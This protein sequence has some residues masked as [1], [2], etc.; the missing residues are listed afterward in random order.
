M[1]AHHLL[2]RLTPPLVAEFALCL[3]THFKYMDFETVRYITLHAF[4]IAVMGFTSL[5]IV[6][7]WRLICIQH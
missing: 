2:R 3:W 7:A 1:L 5:F 6:T 4:N